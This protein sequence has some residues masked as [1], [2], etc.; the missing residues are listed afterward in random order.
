MNRQSLSFPNMKTLILTN[1]YD[2][3]TDY[4]IKYI[5]SKNIVRLN[6]DLYQEVIID[7]TETSLKIVVNEIE[8]TDKDVSK[9]LW[10][11]PFNSDLEVDK[12]VN[13]EIKYIFREIYNYFH[14]QNKTILIVPN[15][16]NYLGKI[17]QMTIGKKYFTVPSWAVKLNADLGDG[18]CVVKSLS[19]EITND[20]KVIYSTKVSREK[21]DNQYPWFLQDLVEAELDVTVVFIDG[22]TF[23]YELAR[24]ENLVDWRKEINLSNQHW[25]THKIQ[26]NFKNKIIEYMNHLG[27]KFGRLDFLFCRGEYYFLEI[28]PNGQWAWLDL[29]NKNG[30]MQEMILQVSP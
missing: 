11:K 26:N 13:A 30:L 1:S 18:I 20:N 22:K 27:L 3:T 12:Y 17:V 23:A 24:K 8:I 10:R 7:I 2:A 14:I 4:L 15:V 29:D 6:F 25:K 16:E 28:N 19:S 9:V 21:L 5:G